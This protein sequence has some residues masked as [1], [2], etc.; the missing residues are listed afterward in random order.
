MSI[1]ELT[2]SD[3]VDVEYRFAADMHYCKNSRLDGIGYYQV[4]MLGYRSSHLQCNDRDP[5][6]PD[7]VNCL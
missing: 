1:L 3:A 4:S 7:P 6:F 5:S 2:P